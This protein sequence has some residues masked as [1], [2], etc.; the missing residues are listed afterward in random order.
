MEVIRIIGREFE[1]DGGDL[2]VIVEGKVRRSEMVE[3]EM[4][5]QGS[6][7]SI[8]IPQMRQNSIHL[9]PSNTSS[10]YNSKHHK[11]TQPYPTLHPIFLINVMHGDEAR[12]N[13]ILNHKCK[14]S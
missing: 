12:R 9:D 8:R 13:Q 7:E 14:Q 5:K 2:V 1:K 11:F 3:E 6:K 10:S 4:T